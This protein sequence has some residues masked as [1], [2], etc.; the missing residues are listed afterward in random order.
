M[1]RDVMT[2]MCTAVKLFQKLRHMMYHDVMTIFH[3]LELRSQPAMHTFSPQP[4]QE[5][6]NYYSNATTAR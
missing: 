3:E 6:N 5:S 2:C 1:Y 4:P